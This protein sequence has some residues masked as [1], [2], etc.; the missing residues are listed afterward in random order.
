M[1]SKSTTNF[2]MKILIHV[3]HFNGGVVAVHNFQT[4]TALS[5][6][7]SQFQVRQTSYLLFS[8]LIKFLRLSGCRQEDIFRGAGYHLPSSCQPPAQHNSGS[9][10]HETSSPPCA[11]FSQQKG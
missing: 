3:I 1:S 6:M 8:F 7:Y 11:C 5:V 2:R 9:Y 10:A 4:F